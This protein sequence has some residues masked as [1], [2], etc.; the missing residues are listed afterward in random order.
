MGIEDLALP[1]GEYGWAPGTPV[2]EFAGSHE[3]RFT[4]P[5]ELTAA[6]LKA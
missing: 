1:P 4:R 3:A 6:L 5:D 2:V